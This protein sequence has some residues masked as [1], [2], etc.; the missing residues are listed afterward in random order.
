V[1]LR[2]Q[3]AGYLLLLLLLLLVVPV[4]LLLQPLPLAVVVL[5]LALLEP[6]A[7]QQPAEDQKR[8]TQSAAKHAT[9]TASAAHHY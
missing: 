5:L 9:G 4:H 8:P 2:L 7:S 3:Q 1:L 6:C